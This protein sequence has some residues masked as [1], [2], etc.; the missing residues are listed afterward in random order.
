[1][2]RSKFA[3]ESSLVNTLCAI[4]IKGYWDKLLSP[5]IGSLVTSSIISQTLLKLSPYGF[6]SLVWSFFKWVETVPQYKHSLQSSWNMICILTK[7]RHFTKARDLLEKIAKKDYL[8][9]PSVLNA[10]VSVDV[11]ADVNSHVL[12]WLV[13]F[14]VNSNKNS[15]AIQVFEH[16]R[17]CRYKPDLHACTV[18]L[19][20][21]V[22]ERSIDTVWKLYKKMLKVGVCPNLH[23]YNVLI[24]ACC[25]SGDVERAEKLLVEMESKKILPD[26]ITYNTLISLY[27][28]KGMHYEVL[29]VQDQME[30]GGVCPD[31]VTFNLL[32]YGYCREGRMREAM[33][34]F[35]E[36]TGVSPNSVTYTTLIDGYCRVGDVAEALQL[37]DTMETKGLY[38]G[39]VTYNAVL[40][41]LCEEGR[42]RDANKLLNEMNDRKIVADNVTCNTLINAYCKIGDM[43]SALKVKNKM[44]EAGL[45]PDQFTYKALIHGFCKAW[46]IENAKE[47]LFN[48]LGAGF[49]ASSCTY[50]WLMDLYCERN[51]DE[52]ILN[53]PDELV[54]HGFCADITVYRAMI[55]RLCKKE[56]IDCG[57]RIFKVMQAR[58]IVGDAIICTSLAFAHWRV[59]DVVAASALFDEMYERRLMV[60]LKI[61]R[62]INASYAK[63]ESCLNLFWSTVRDRGLIS[64][65]ICQE[66]LQLGDRC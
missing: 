34:L 13:I 7:H 49:S 63:D 53:L 24:H 32:I 56:R 8:S 45:K 28:R 65:S 33:K 46:E 39:V 37:L 15:D 66:L 57:Q 54:Q 30:R 12:S 2:E 4:V 35:K 60:T 21:L 26:L 23:V 52:A 31:I 47:M 17:V 61:F 36:I 9:S 10:L 43:R 55:R 5:K 59:G 38:L 50:A 48:M 27:C 41:K 25:R 14:Y 18:L 62:C 51:D 19:N 1:M 22:K 64:K 58:G 44:L 42:I 20:S 29:S 40:R 6:P 11:D 3:S 16:M